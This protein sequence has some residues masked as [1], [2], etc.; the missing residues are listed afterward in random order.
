MTTCEIPSLLKEKI[1][2]HAKRRVSNKCS[3][4]KNNFISEPVVSILNPDSK[5][6]DVRYTVSWS[7]DN[8]TL[9]V[10]CILAS[11]FGCLDMGIYYTDYSVGIFK[12]S[13][14]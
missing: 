5:F 10:E 9:S 2:K 8:R 7:E 13:L 3:E 12:E 14:G 1:L 4:E 11:Q 6:D